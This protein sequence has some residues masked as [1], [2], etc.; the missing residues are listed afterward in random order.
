MVVPA[1]LLRTALLVAPLQ[2][3]SEVSRA[4][5]PRSCSDG[6]ISG[7]DEI[8]LARAR[9]QSEWSAS[10]LRRKPRFLP[11]TGARQWARA[12]PLDTEEDWMEWLADGEKRNPYIPSRPDKV[13]ADAGW[14]GWED[15]LNGP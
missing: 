13:Y 5:A 14:A 4:C 12:M 8:R 3:Q 2:Q 15:F 6:D 1:L 11:F 10:V 9:L 7:S